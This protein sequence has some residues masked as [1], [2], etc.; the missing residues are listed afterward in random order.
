MKSFCI[1]TCS[2]KR[3]PPRRARHCFVT[4]CCKYDVKPYKCSVL[5]Q[6]SCPVDLFK[7]SLVGPLHRGQMRWEF[8]RGHCIPCMPQQAVVGL[9]GSGNNVTASSHATVSFSCNRYVKVAFHDRPPIHLF[10]AFT[11][12]Q[13][14]RPHA[15]CAGLLEAEASKLAPCGHCFRSSLEV[16]RQESV[17]DHLLLGEI[18]G[19][20]I[21]VVVAL[22]RSMDWAAV[23]EAAVILDSWGCWRFCV[24]INRFNSQWQ[25]HPSL[26]GSRPE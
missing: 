17:G 12:D 6:D 18:M 14:K 9:R 5:I 10:Y 11:Q 7:L 22:P 24:W 26:S 21:T 2:L 16:T 8:E 4:V 13:S 15:R 3:T 19:G 23:Q 25:T 20:G 1:A